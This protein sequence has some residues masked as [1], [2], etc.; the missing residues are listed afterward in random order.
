MWE[1]AGA[2]RLGPLGGIAVGPAGV[3][4]SAALSI[5]PQLSVL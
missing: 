3:T 2:T 5:I 1:S 4:A